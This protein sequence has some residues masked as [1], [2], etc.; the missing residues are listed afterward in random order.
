MASVL[1]EPPRLGAPIADTHA[2][3]DMLDD[4]VGAL[5]RAALADV[6]R[7]VTVVDA[8]ETPERTLDGLQAWIDDAANRL[9]AAGHT[10]T[11]AP[12]V[13][14]ILGV[15]PH[16]AKDFHDAIE[17][18]MLELTADPRVTGIGE[19]GLDY[20]YDHSPREQQRDVFRRQLAI[21]HR[22]E[23]PVIVHLREAHDDGFEILEDLG[24]PAGG[25]VLHCFTGDAD[26]ARRFLEIGCYVSF[27]GPVTFKNAD[28]IRAAACAVPLDRLLAETDAPFMAPEP[29]RG[30]RNEP[31]WTAFTVA[32]IAEARGQDTASVARAV[33][34]NAERVFFPTE[35]G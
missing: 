19:I 22:C 28:A 33:Y 34:E 8:T 14:I 10:G 32:R 7:V 11:A 3:L 29:H 13:R 16:N 35:G 5:E 2:H 15:H 26:L 20:H 27:A 30:E 24:L 23:L 31:A 21:A 17:H 4:P 12:D 18:R 1:I 9:V 6:T 25:C